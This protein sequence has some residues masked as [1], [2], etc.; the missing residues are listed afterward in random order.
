MEKSLIKAAEKVELKINE[1]KTEYTVV[2][3]KN[4]NRVQE[5]VIEVEG[6]RFKIVNQ[7]K[8][9]GS[10]II[11]NNDIKAEISMRLQ[12]ANKCF[13]K[14]YKICRSRSTSKVL[15]GRMCLTLLRSIVFYGTETW[16]LR[17][18]EKLRMA[19][20]EIKELRKMYEVYFDAQTSE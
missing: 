12:S 4:R 10:V 11:Q 18:T 14:L 15:K 7:F 2:S 5:E 3:Q 6:S 13:F 1:E 9:L 20:F 19:I 8:Y 17:K 16:L